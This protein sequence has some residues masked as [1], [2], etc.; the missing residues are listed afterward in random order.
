VDPD[1]PTLDPH[2]W[3]AFRQTA[4]AILDRA[5]DGIQQLPSQ[6]VWRPMP[7][8]QRAFLANERL[9]QTGIGPEAALADV[10]SRV[11]P[12]AMHSGHPRFWAWVQGSGFPLAALGDLVASCLNAHLA[13]FD[14][15]PAIAE[16]TTLRWLAELMGF[17]RDASGV[18][19]SSG[20]MANL[21]A[22]VVAR[23][24][25][26]PARPVLYASTEVHGWAR[27]ALTVLGL[28]PDSLRLIPVTPE[29]TIDSRA[30]RAEIAAGRQQGHT[31]FCVIGTAGTVNTGAIDPLDELAAIA[32]QERIWFHVDGAFGAL[33]RLHPDLAPLLN[34]IE[35]A[36]S[37]AFDLHKWGS[38]PFA[39][40]T[41]LVRD[42]AAHL[43]AFASTPSYMAPDTRGPLAGGVPFA[44]R[45]ID[46]SRG[47][48]SLKVWVALRAFGAEHF[49]RIIRQN[50]EDARRFAAAILAH[51]NFELLAP[52]PLNIV[53]FR[54]TRPGADLDALNHELL[55]RLQESGV[56]LISS[57]I[58]SGRFA[59]RLANVNHRSTP[60]DFG[61]LLET[62]ERLAAA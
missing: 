57:T 9:P 28:P 33:A 13:G 56:A 14:H 53:C 58:V 61:L 42:P 52:A 12:Y 50:V 31:P 26:K 6:P 36:D 2:N 19:C 54:Y 40:A 49:A 29:F 38:M 21:L 51:P 16:Q 7:P 46:L 17:P 5:L 25:L 37:L 27:K 1:R 24:Q 8:E 11:A 30:L 18:F 10:F 47:F 43:A 55:L 60:A 35:K 45:G 22:L 32:A 23:N 39:C 34:G 3:P 41:L 44:D 48:D 59:L 20:T 4:H 62:L 15:A